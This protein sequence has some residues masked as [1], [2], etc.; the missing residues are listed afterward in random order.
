LVVGYDLHSAAFVY[1]VQMFRLLKTIKVQINS[2]D[3]RVAGHS[4]FMLAACISKNIN[5]GTDVVPKSKRMRQICWRV[6]FEMLTD[7]N[8]CTIF[9]PRGICLCAD[10]T[11][12]HY[13]QKSQENHGERRENKKYVCRFCW[14]ISTWRKTALVAGDHTCVLCG[15]SNLC[16]Q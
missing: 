7:P 11:K 15:D 12:A 5:L 9:R 3:T 10:W 8:H 6:D 14:N 2:P 4:K 1:P 16:G 13:G